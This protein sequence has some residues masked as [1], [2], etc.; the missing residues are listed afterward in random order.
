M[1]PAAL[2]LLA[3]ASAPPVS[4]SCA[5]CHAP[6]EAPAGVHAPLGC[7]RCHLGDPAGPTVALAHK[8]L[9][10]EPGA[11]DTVE[12]TC[13][14]SG[15]H[16]EQTARVQSSIM[17]T[18]AGLIDVDRSAFGETPQPGESMTELLGTATPTPAQDHLRHLCAGCHLHNRKGNRDDAVSGSGA[19]CSACHSANRSRAFEAHPTIDLAPPDVRCLGCHSRS[20]RISLSYQGLAEVRGAPATATLHDG[21]PAT[22]QQPDVH[23]AAGLSCIDCHLHTELMGDGTAYA[24]EEE[25]TEIRCE[26][27]HGPAAPEAALTDATSLRLIRQ[28]GET[29]SPEEPVR[30]GIRGTPIWNLRKG[31]GAWILLE[32]DGQGSHPVTQIPA[33]HSSP[34]HAK[35]SCSACHSRWTPSCPDCHTAREASGSQWDFATGA[36]TPGR[37]VETADTFTT[38]T[39]TLGV[40]PDGT[41]V[42]VMPGMIWTLETAEG[43]RHDRRFAR[44]EPHTTAR[45]GRS[46]VECHGNGAAIGLG[47][48]MLDLVAGTFSPRNPAAEDPAMA[49]DGWIRLFGP[50]GEG[51]R[52]GL[53]SFS[54]AEQRAIL[55]VGLCL[56]CHPTAEDP[57]Y[58]AFAA[59]IRDLVEGPDR[60]RGSLPGWAKP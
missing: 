20:A 30:V 3:C 37:W 39:P 14:S 23:A 34:A 51:T 47:T 48:G 52:P 12:R 33:E 41:V 29:R 1:I 58:V 4:D 5:S 16:Q 18:G 22:R 46:C 53:R 59:S 57:I 32:K 19:G 60:C 2:L 54:A 7:A 45:E 11:L 38:S 15:C 55:R 44:V 50:T 9:E 24:H 40:S 27:C 21:R 17:A 26:S 6:S 25:A 49:A 42:A 28:H 8:G 36:E 56:A 43:P 31:D 35:I 13:G 10:R